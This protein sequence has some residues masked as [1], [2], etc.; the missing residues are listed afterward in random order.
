MGLAQRELEWHGPTLYLNIGGRSDL[1]A[2]AV[3]RQSRR[4]WSPS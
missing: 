1:E 3:Q 4:S 2:I